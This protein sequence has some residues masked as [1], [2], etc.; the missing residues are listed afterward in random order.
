MR[1]APRIWGLS[2]ASAGEVGALGVVAEEGVEH[3]LHVAQVGLDLAADLRQQHA[4][5]RAPAH[6]VQHR[7]RRAPG[8]ARPARAASRRAI[9]ASTCCGNSGE[10]F[11]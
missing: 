9:I 8:G 2:R 6:L 7:P 1:S 10:R 5:L 3:L 11:A 4:L